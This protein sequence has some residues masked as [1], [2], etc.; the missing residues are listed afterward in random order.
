ME[1]LIKIKQTQQFDISG[2]QIYFQ[3]STPN[4]LSPKIGTL[5][6]ARQWTNFGSFIDVTQYTG[7]Q[8]KTKITFTTERD[9]E[10]FIAPGTTQVKKAA[11]T[12]ISFET[13]AFRLI[14]QWLIDDVSA[15]LNSVDVELWHID[16]NGQLCGI[17][18]QFIIK[19]TDLEWCQTD[20]CILDCTIKQKD[21]LIN[22]IK[23]TLI[24]D[25]WQ[26]WF[27]ETVSPFDPDNNKRNPR[28]SY[29]KEIRPNGQLVVMWYLMSTIAFVSY[30][31]S[32]L[33]I[34]IV[35]PFI[36]VMNGFLIAWNSIIGIINALGGN[37]TP[38]PLIKFKNLNDFKDNVGNFFVEAA[39]CGREHPAPLIRKY[40]KNVCDKCGVQ[41]DEVTADIFF[42]ST[43]N[44]ETSTRGKILSENP[45]HNACY[46]N[47]QT[48]KGVR[49]FKNLSMVGYSE[50]DITTHYIAANSPIMALD[51]FLDELKEVF[52]CE[53]NIRNGKLYFKRK[54]WFTVSPSGSVWD[55]SEYGADRNKLLEGICFN[56][57]GKKIPAFTEG[58]YQVDPTDT[59]GNSAR[60]FMNGFVSFGD[61]S[62]VPVYDGKMDKLVNFGATKFRNDG[63]D[64][65][66][67][68]DAMQV[69]INGGWAST[70]ISTTVMLDVVKPQIQE[71]ADYCL[72]MKD[73]VTTYP[74]IIIWDGQ[75]YLN[76]KSQKYYKTEDQEPTINTKY[77]TSVLG[78][79]LNWNNVIKHQPQTFVRG[80]SI[81]GASQ[82]FAKYRV[83]D[84][85]GVWI[86]DV[87]A[88]LIN[89]PM[90]F[91]PDFENS[92][93]D[94]FHWI[95]DPNARAVVNQGWSG[96]IEL[97][98]DELQR[99]GVFDDSSNI[100]LGEKVNLLSGKQGVITN[101]EVSYD[102]QDING[103]YIKLEGT[104]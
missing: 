30:T 98:C 55:F 67:I 12:S 70:F 18:K 58:L 104:L 21:E 53:W 94:W 42:A 48:Q 78:I 37:L 27:D 65:D 61:A 103:M 92:L 101:I 28:F 22:C 50:P 10:G 82:P 5:P 93:W 41:V 8:F 46:L 52:N 80:G 81:L 45:Y 62:K 77:N 88:Y 40:I 95:D 89:Y 35:N 68:M 100:V 54:D 71:Y 31:L 56:W 97:C 24:S 79:P 1:L 2:N 69:C 38:V 86:Y 83:R 15:Q 36:F 63:V 57:N 3:G 7:D 75:G 44:I 64:T 102:T 9:N 87:P 32:I 39:G 11:S 26:H 19:A 51:Q 59:C 17:Y 20:N 25:N 91:A 47:A 72:L 23:S 33:W 66:Y 49:R 43:I 4:T 73:D 90:Y 96:K 76:A 29:C 84:P 74:K 6:V 85:L 14:K 16:N 13:V 99:A 60:S 34:T